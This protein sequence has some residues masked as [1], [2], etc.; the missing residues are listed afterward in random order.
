MEFKEEEIMFPD[1]L[2][3]A[4]VLVTD[5]QSCSQV[6]SAHNV[7]LTDSQICAMDPNQQIGPCAVRRKYIVLLNVSR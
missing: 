3:K 7:T 2:Q 1:R 5:K 4:T 6:Y